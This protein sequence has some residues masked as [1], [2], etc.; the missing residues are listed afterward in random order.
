MSD[1][2]IST[3]LRLP[4]TD[5]VE[6][7]R[8]ALKA[9]GFGIITEIDVSRTVKEKLGEDMPPYIILGACNPRLAHQAI[10]ARPDVGLLMPCNVCV[11]DNGDGTLSVAALNVR[12]VFELVS[13]PRLTDTAQRVDAALRRAI[14]RLATA[15]Q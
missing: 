2:G 13:D 15:G 8:A 1:L 9:E 5:G 14:D 11:W 4:Y 6:Q 12:A 10:M 7:V 3:T